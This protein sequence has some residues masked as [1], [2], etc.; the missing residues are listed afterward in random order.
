MT[1]TA[2]SYLRAGLA[3]VPAKDKHPLLEYK[4]WKQKWSWD[5]FKTQFPNISIFRTTKKA[6]QIAIICGKVSGNLECIDIDN[7]SPL[8]ETILSHMMEEAC[9]NWFDTSILVERTRKGGY[10]IVYRCNEIEGNKKFAYYR[11][12]EEEKYECI[13]ESRGEGGL[14]IAAPTEGYTVVHG[15]YRHIGAIS[16]DERAILHNIAKSYN[17]KPIKKPRNIIYKA[18]GQTLFEKFNG[19]PVVFGLAQACLERHG[20]VFHGEKWVSRPGKKEKA[21]SATWGHT[22]AP[23]IFYVWSSN[24]LPFDSEKAYSPYQIIRMLDY[25]NDS[26]GFF[27]YVKDVIDR[28]K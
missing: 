24:A 9:N 17:Q 11:N 13:V 3:C 10:H 23:F 25:P 22:Q 28:H 7:N 15:D 8:T 12:E 6:D 4:H 5:E 16:P 18:D 19:L 27:T 21:N 2:L 1:S 20:W 14:F 26:D